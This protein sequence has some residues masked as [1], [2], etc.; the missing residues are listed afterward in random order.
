MQGQVDL[1][2]EVLTLRQ[3]NAYLKEELAQLKRMIFGRKRER[4]IPSDIAQ[5]ALFE[6]QEAVE[7]AAQQ[8][9]TYQR[10]KPKKTGKAKRLLLPA[11]LPREERLIEPQG[12]DWQNSVRIGEKVSEVLEYTPGKF[13]VTKTVRPVYKQAESIKVADL[14]TQVIPNGN[15][16][17]SLLAYLLVSKFIDHLPFYR[18]VQIFKRDGMKIPE[19]TLSGWFR[20]T[21]ELLVP[22][23]ELMVQ[24]LTNTDYLQADESPIPVLSNQKPGSTHKGYQ[25]VFLLPKCKMVVFQYHQSRGKSVAQEILKD[26]KGCL[27]TDGYAGYE[28]LG[29][30]VDITH[31]G[32]MAHA[33][34]KFE[35]ALENDQSLASTALNM[36]QQLYAIER[37]TREEKLD[38]QAVYQL[39]QKEALSVLN[40]MKSFLEK[41][42]SKVLPK[43]AIGKAFTYSLNQW[44]QLIRY[45]ENGHWQIDNNAVENKIRP[46]A[47]GRKNYLFAGSHNAAQQAA[48]MYSF[49]GTCKLN[50]I[51]PLEWLTQ[52]L[53][54]IPEYKINQLHELLPIRK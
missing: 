36:F 37:K 39:R 33:R 54:K 9:I 40:E 30:R 19:S 2:E 17:A 47:L 27:Q 42:Y 1:Q 11:Y 18:Q 20:K 15:A 51:N 35:A 52:T 4:F 43:S 5:H 49:F 24:Q 7:A 41:N 45:T 13:Y 23:Y 53:R 34:R 3:E 10:E 26:F 6:E 25:W 14:P 28:E 21:C 16:G 50:D 8:T 38:Q 22:L 29:R 46:L 44:Q 48:M 32:C 12:V 31:L